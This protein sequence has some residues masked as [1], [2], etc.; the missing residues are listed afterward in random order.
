[1]FRFFVRGL[2]IAC[3]ALLVRVAA[4][5][6]HVRVPM[7]DGTELATDVYTPEGDGP[8]PVILL[9]STYGRSGQVADEWLEQGY[10]VVIQD[11]RGM[12]DSAGEAHVFYADGW[13]AGLPT[14]RPPWR[15]LGAAVVQRK[16]GT[17]GGSALAITRCCW[18]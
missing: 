10:A 6:Q 8:W 14:A 15:D 7:E 3:I 12:G 4:E 9:R 1:M 2:L 5:P 17:H 13:R 16:I 11:V 18:R